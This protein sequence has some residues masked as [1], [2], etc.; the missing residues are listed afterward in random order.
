M[1]KLCYTKHLFRVNNVL[2]IG[3]TSRNM[4]ILLNPENLLFMTFFNIPLS[5]DQRCV[6]T[7]YT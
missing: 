3:I 5:E 1:C 7:I 4:I 6:D 2:G